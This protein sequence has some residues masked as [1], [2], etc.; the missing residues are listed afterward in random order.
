MPLDVSLSL[1]IPD[2]RSSVRVVGDSSVQITANKELS[3]TVD[4]I[5]SVS[6]TAHRV[7]H[8][9]S[10][11]LSTRIGSQRTVLADGFD[12]QDQLAGMR[13]DLG[14]TLSSSQV[15][16]LLD[17]P[18]SIVCLNGDLIL[19]SD[20]ITEAWITESADRALSEGSVTDCL[21]EDGDVRCGYLTR[22]ETDQP[23]D[24]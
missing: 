23:A 10:L 17:E 2:A 5:K 7:K 22:L 1:S 9:T 14:E 4:F 18:D 19:P 3:K 16:G 24:E 20:E 8:V 13:V 21:S 6:A 15:R 11:S 12:E